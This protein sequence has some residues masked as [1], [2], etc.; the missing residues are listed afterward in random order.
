MLLGR[1]KLGSVVKIIDPKNAELSQLPH[2]VTPDE[3][4]GGRAILETLHEFENT[5]RKRQAT[6]NNL[7]KKK[8]DAVKWWDAKMHPSILFVDE[9]VAC[10]SLFPT[11]AVKEEPGYSI[12]EFDDSLKRII[13]MGASAGCFVIVSIAEASVGE[14]GLPTMLKNALTTKVLFKPTLDEG[15]HIWDGEKLKAF[16]ERAYSAG[17]AWFS[18]TDGLHDDVAFVHF[19]VMEFPVYRELGRLMEAYYGDSC[20]HAAG[21]F[22]HRRRPCAKNR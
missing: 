15:R 9:F 14:G 20:R 10:R 7:S 2:T 12:K 8:G 17:D 21:A 3:D 11:K 18:S 4:G 6:L 22:A 5:M 1:D 13:T 16:P 19:P